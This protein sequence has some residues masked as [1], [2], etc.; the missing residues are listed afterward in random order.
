MSSIA[1]LF[2]RIEAFSAKLMLKALYIVNEN[3][4]FDKREVY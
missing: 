2:L 3:F 4:A 1:H